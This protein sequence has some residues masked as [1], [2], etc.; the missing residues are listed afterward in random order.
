MKNETSLCQIRRW[1]L[2]DQILDE[3]LDN[4]SS[5]KVTIL[6]DRCG[7]DTGLRLEVEKLL[8]ATEKAADFMEVSALESAS[9][10]LISKPPKA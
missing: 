2:I 3:L 4:S 9:E 5:Q 8:A 7:A 6:T 10:H 1:E